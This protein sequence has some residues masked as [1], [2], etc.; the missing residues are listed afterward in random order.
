MKI[1]AGSWDVLPV[2]DLM[3]RIGNVAPR[4][5]YR[6]FNMGIGMVV[7]V[8]LADVHRLVAHLDEVGEKHYDIGRVVEGEQEVTIS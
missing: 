2:Y 1:N 6:T 3:R 5:M 7:V 4:E 8:S